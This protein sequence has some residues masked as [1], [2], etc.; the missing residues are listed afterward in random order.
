VNKLFCMAFIL[1]WIVTGT[2]NLWAKEV[3]ITG[4]GWTVTADEARAQLTISHASL[5]T[6][7]QT[8]I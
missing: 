1:A 4:S 3:S 8:F 6:I 7:V 5:G 2:L